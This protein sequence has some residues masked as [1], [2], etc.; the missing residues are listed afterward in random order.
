MILPYQYPDGRIS[1]HMRYSIHPTAIPGWYVIVWGYRV[2]ACWKY[3]WVSIDSVFFDPSDNES[4]YIEYLQKQR[5]K[6]LGERRSSRRFRYR[7]SG[8]SIKA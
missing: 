5:D 3:R 1:R 4:I 7:I 2:K 6:K 8:K